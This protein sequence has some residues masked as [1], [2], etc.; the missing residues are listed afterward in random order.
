[1]EYARP[2]EPKNLT[3]EL[4][5]GGSNHVLCNGIP[6]SVPRQTSSFSEA[7]WF[8]ADEIQTATPQWGEKMLKEVAE[9]V[10]DFMR[11]FAKA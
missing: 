11:K 1:M 9:F 6:I 5:Y 8:G 10:V 7:G 4:V 2:F 3:E